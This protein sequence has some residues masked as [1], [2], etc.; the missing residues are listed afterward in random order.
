VNDQKQGVLVRVLLYSGRPDPEFYLSDAGIGELRGRLEK[1]VGGEHI[2][3]APPGG[4]GYRGFLVEN[5]GNVAGI[6][7][8]FTVYRGVL[9]EPPGP[10]ASHWRD[11]GEVESWLLGQASEQG[12]GD[13]LKA[14]G[15]APQTAG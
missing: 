2:H 13:A 7:A 6:P 1:T 11:S 15:A 3:P 5:R 12:L 8:A 4:L 9:A 10:D 14:F